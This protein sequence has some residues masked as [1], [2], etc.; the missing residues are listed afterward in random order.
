[1]CKCLS[2]ICELEKEDFLGM[3]S[4]YFKWLQKAFSFYWTIE[5]NDRV[6]LLFFTKSCSDSSEFCI[7]TEAVQH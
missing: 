7:V 4:E 5:N 2:L 1:M 6:S 3:N